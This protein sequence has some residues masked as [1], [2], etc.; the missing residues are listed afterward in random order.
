MFNTDLAVNGKGK[1]H[2]ITGHKDPERE[3]RYSSTLSLISALD[4]GGYS[5]PRPGR[6]TPRER[7][8][9]HYIGSCVDLRVDLDRCEKSRPH[10]DSIPGLSCA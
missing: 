7:P 10:C 6:F 3:Y 2:P 4:G 5:T 8:G 1:G 9:T